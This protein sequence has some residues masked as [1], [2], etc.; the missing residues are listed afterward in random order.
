MTIG[1]PLASDAFVRR[2]SDALDLDPDEIVPEARLVE[3]LGLDSFDLVELLTLVE[4][5]GVRFPDNV[6]VGI[7]TVGDLYREY[8]QRATRTAEE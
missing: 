5:L 1:A 3:D 4:E 2:M 8:Q 7:Q 6:A